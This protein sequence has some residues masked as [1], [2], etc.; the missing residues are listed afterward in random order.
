MNV[1]EMFG[2]TVASMGKFIEGEGHIRVKLIE[3]GES[4]IRAEKIL[5]T[6]GSRPAQIPAFPLAREPL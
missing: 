5:L 4:E 2:I 3:G 1:T 6:T